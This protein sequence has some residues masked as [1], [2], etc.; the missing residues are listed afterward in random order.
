M[1]D[2]IWQW[3]RAGYPAGRMLPWWMV[4]VR[5]LLYPV[6]FAYW[7][8]GRDRGYQIESD[9]WLIGGVRYSSAALHE[10]SL[11]HGR[12]YRVTRVGDV[13]EFEEVHL[14]DGDAVTR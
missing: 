4:C 10:L 7:R 9:M 12:C 1:R 8:L 13:V 11:S 6:D 14:I 2:T 5:A 3:L